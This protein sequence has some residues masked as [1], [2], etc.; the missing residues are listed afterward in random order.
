[1]GFLWGDRLQSYMHWFLEAFVQ[2]TR[3][4]IQCPSKSTWRTETVGPRQVG[5]R[6]IQN[7]GRIAKPKLVVTGVNY[8][9]FRARYPFDDD[10]HNYL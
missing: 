7:M 4:P 10:C 6:A 9:A 8:E 1:M 5:M 3:L 2:L